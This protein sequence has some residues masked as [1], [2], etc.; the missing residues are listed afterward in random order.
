MAPLSRAKKK[1]LID[2]INTKKNLVFAIHPILLLGHSNPPMKVEQC[3]QIEE[4]ATTLQHALKTQF[5]RKVDIY[6]KWQD[7]NYITRCYTEVD[8]VYDEINVI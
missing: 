2:V 3:L 5:G 7:R 6:K 4:A 1:A 8:T